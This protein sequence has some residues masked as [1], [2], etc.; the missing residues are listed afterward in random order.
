[1]DPLLINY[2]LAEV[3]RTVARLRIPDCPCMCVC[4]CVSVCVCVCLDQNRTLDLL[5]RFLTYG[6]AEYRA[7]SYEVWEGVYT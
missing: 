7:K 3:L 1:M 6:H 5:D 2:C 4:L